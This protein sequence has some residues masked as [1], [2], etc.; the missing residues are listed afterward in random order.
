MTKLKSILLWLISFFYTPVTV[1]ETQ[2]KE[3]TVKLALV[4]IIT[5]MLANGVSANTVQITV[6]DD[7]GAAL[8]NASLYL[9]AD[10]GATVTPARGLTDS[11]G[12]LTASI[13]STTAGACTVT[14][15]LA[16]T[17]SGSIQVYFVAVPAPVAA[18]VVEDPSPEVGVETK[19]GVADL[20][21]ALN[22]IEGG[23]A[24]L[25][26][27]AKDELKELAKKYL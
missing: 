23:V 7:S 21:A 5:S 20:D 14:A 12:Q 10:N 2:T 19:A 22:F 3:N 18:I 15:E 17:T 13:I 6:T 9:S 11:N 25:G 27:A 16:D 4:S 24:Q 8:P 1:T 26:D